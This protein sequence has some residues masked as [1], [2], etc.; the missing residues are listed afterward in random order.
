VTKLPLDTHAVVAMVA[1]RGL[2]ILDNPHIANLGPESAHVAALAGAE[3]YKAIGA[4]EN[5]SYHSAV[6]SGMHC[7]ARSEHQGPLREAVRKHLLKTG[8]T[9]GSIQASGSASGDLASW[10]EWTTP[11]LN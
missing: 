4:E 8:T 2:L 9:A 11:T 1:P 6:A 7:E 10:R 5:I 3:V